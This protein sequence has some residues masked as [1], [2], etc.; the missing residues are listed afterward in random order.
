MEIVRNFP[1]QAIRDYYHK[2]YRPDQQGIV[3][4]GDINVDEMEKKVIDLFSTI[5]M[6]ENAAERTYPSVSDNKEPIYV[7]FTD[8][9][10]RFPMIMVSFKTDKIPFEMR[11]TLEAYLQTQVVE[12]LLSTMINNRLNDYAKNPE[13]KYVQAG[14]SFGDFYVS[15]TKAAFDTYIIPK[16]DVKAAFEDAMGIVARACKTGFMES[17]LVRARDELLAQYEKLY[18]ERNNTKTET[19]AREICRHFIDNEAAPGIEKE[20]ELMKMMLPMLPVRAF[21]EGAKELL[22]PENQVIVVSEPQHDEMTVI[23]KEEMVGD[24]QNILN[25]EYEAYV[26]EVITDPL[27]EKLPAPAKIVSTSEGKFGTTV[28]TLSNG[29]KVVVKP[30]DFKQDEI[31]M[32]AYKDGG[33]RSYD[34]KEAIDVLLSG[35]AVEVSKLGNFDQIKLG[36]YLSGKNVSLGYGIGNTMNSLSGKSTVKDLPTFMEL[37]YATFTELNPDENAYNAYIDQIKTILKNNDKNPTSVF[38]RAISK[39]CY[40]GNPMFQQPTVEMVESANYARELEIVKNSLANAADY[41]FIF[42][43]NIDLD[44]F[45]P[46][47]E[48]YVATLPSTGKKSPAP[49]QLTSIELAKGVID[50]KFTQPMQVPGTMVMSNISDRNI[51]YNIENSVKIDMIGEILS[52]IYTDTLR[53]EEGGTYSPYAYGSFNP[54]TNTWQIVSIFQTN[55]K[56]QDKLIARANEELM[57]LLSKGADE[58]N[59]NKVKEAALKQYEINVRTNSYWDNNLLQYERGF[60]DIT[61]HKALSKILHSPTSTSSCQNSTME[62]TAF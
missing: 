34:T 7:Y 3:I 30:T 19:L 47:L 17:E 29:V 12:I 41:T 26:D 59:F 52:N 8:K 27:I 35:D 6:P 1:P 39:A 9:E 15:K 23:T 44:S 13:C 28:F 2:W 60:D 14:V 5:P 53:E 11:N 56:V 42:T 18:N 33:K 45:K 43:G 57:K 37:V 55:D 20:Y 40:G 49:A 10:L 16:G 48:Q 31:V 58:T 51:E 4:V 54:Y 50:D 24:L 38:Q 62:R 61:D 25:K 46:L 21:N 32:T 22:T 36:K